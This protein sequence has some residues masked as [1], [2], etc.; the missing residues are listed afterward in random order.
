MVDDE[1]AVRKVVSR[2]VE[3]LG[4]R[5]MQAGDGAEA[6]DMFRANAAEIGCVL[7]DLNMPRLDGEEV[8]RA[9]RAIRPDA[10]VLMMSGYAEQETVARFRGLG[11]AGVL[12]KPISS[13]MLRQK[14]EL[15][16]AAAR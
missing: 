9:M 11:A 13:A 1:P 10:R 6:I 4:M 15:A 12:Q 5:V 16:L 3:R 2:M 8:F 7:L 14:L